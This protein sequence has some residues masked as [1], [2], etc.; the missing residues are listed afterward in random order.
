MC[1]G[2]SRRPVPHTPVRLASPFA[3]FQNI[4]AVGT[5]LYFKLGERV[6]AS[7]SVLLLLIALMPVRPELMA[8]QRYQIHICAAAAAA[9]AGGSKP[10]CKSGVL[11]LLIALLLLLPELMADHR[12]QIHI[13]KV[14]QQ[15]AAA[16]AAASSRTQQQYLSFILLQSCNTYCVHES[17]CRCC[18]GRAQS[19]SYIINRLLLGSATLSKTQSV[20]VNLPQAL[21]ECSNAGSPNLRTSTPK[22]A[23]RAACIANTPQ[24]TGQSQLYGKR[25]SGTP[26]MQ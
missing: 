16:A 19:N 2:N 26:A 25:T 11:L 6:A 17:G 9:A 15:Q 13:C 20:H 3:S 23:E 7:M 8:D 18:V 12:Y 1:C 14:T 22:H 10:Q 24:N 4:V 5:H 21:L